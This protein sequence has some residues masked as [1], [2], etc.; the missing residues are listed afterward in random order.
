MNQPIFTNSKNRQAVRIAKHGS[1]LSVRPTL[2]V[3]LGGTGCCA[4]QWFN[5]LLREMYGGIPPFIKLLAIDSDEMEDVDHITHQF[6]KADF[7]N[8]FEDIHVGDII[9]DYSNFPAFHPALRI[10]EGLDLPSAIVERGCQGIS[11]LGRVVFFE[12]WERVIYRAVFERLDALRKSTLREEV[13]SLAPVGQYELSSSPVVHVISSVCGGTGSGMLLDMAYALQYWGNEA[14]NREP[15]VFAHLLLPEAFRIETRT[16]MDKLRAVGHSVLKQIEFFMDSRRPSVEVEYP[17]GTIREF[18]NKNAP[19][20]A[21]YLV[22]G[23]SSDGGGSRTEL[24]QLIARMVR[25]MVIEPA[26]KP[27]F[28]D[29]NN[30]HL[31]IL[32][33]KDSQTKRMMCFSSYGLAYGTVQHPKTDNRMRGLMRQWLLDGIGAST[34]ARFDSPKVEEEISQQLSEYVQAEL[35]PEQIFEADLKSV[36]IAEFS[37]SRYQPTADAAG[38]SSGS[39]WRH[40]ITQVEEHFNK[41]VATEVQAGIKKVYEERLRRVRAHL[42]AKLQSGKPLTGNEK[43]ERGEEI[44]YPLLANAHVYEKVLSRLLAQEADRPSKSIESITREICASLVARAERERAKRQGMDNDKLVRTFAKSLNQFVNQEIQPKE[45]KPF[46]RQNKAIKMSMAEK[47]YREALRQL[48]EEV[49]RPR[50]Q[51]LRN[52]SDAAKLIELHTEEE[53]HGE[54]HSNGSSKQPEAKNPGASAYS[55]SLFELRHPKDPKSPLREPGDRL[56]RIVQ[57]IVKD[58]VE[59]ASKGNHSV[60][61]NDVAVQRLTSVMKAHKPKIDDWMSKYGDLALDAK[62]RMAD[63]S[64]AS[65]HPLFESVQKICKRLTPKIAINKTGRHDSSM[66]VV[67]AQYPDNSCLPVLLKAIVGSDFRGAMIDNEYARKTQTYLQLMNFG[68][69]FCLPALDN[70]DEY[71]TAEK[72]YLEPNVFQKEDLWLDPQWHKLY[73]R[74]LEKVAEDAQA[75]KRKEQETRQATRQRADH[76]LS[77]LA[78]FEALLRPF[79]SEVAQA[80]KDYQEFDSQEDGMECHSRIQ[81]AR[82]ECLLMIDSIR[83]YPIEELQYLPK[84]SDP[85][86]DRIENGLLKSYLIPQVSLFAA[87]VQSRFFALRDAYDDLIMHYEASRGL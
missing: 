63:P 62:F 80:C 32:S 35:K 4:L 9:K 68:I 5:Q 83:K 81:T 25:S 76:T 22:N 61:G 29:L 36:G 34:E 16:I 87:T 19:F 71:E 44:K 41:T 6:P 74:F 72:R 43:D 26:A 30:K 58:Y 57:D 82:P 85:I 56:D 23:H 27:I 64:D 1:L 7:Y 53:E 52:L 28:S 42:Q 70:L 33:T 79:F 20:D 46:P 24:V 2:V 39:A 15:E 13:A 59:S 54:H 38:N 60:N 3:G 67:V 84:L 10:L 11:R 69:G 8:V 55:I 75:D 21:C 78:Q 37:M 73:E 77:Y 47:W 50:V 14:F 40:F 49:V 18:S 86:M 45:G 66:R 48:V 51:E 31:D 17:G 65:S 12:T